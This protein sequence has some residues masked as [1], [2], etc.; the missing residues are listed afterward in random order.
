MKRN[1]IPVNE[2]LFVGNEKKYLNECIDTG[3]IGSDGKFVKKFEDKLSK[4]VGRKYGISVSSGSAALDVAF[5]ALN[6]K[7]NDEVILPTFT[8]ISCLNPILRVGAKPV[9]IDCDPNTWNMDLS[10]VEKK[11]TKKTKIILAVHIYGLPTNMYKLSE[12][13]KK[14]KI[15]IIEDAAELIG[16]KIFKKEC[17]SFGDISTFSFYTNKHITT[18]EGGM[19]FTNDKKIAENCKKLKNL[20]FEKKRFIHREVGWNYRMS[21]IQAAIGLAQLEK[22]KDF[23]KIKRNIGNKYYQGLCDEKYLDFQTGSTNYAKNI[24]WVFGIVLKKNCPITLDE[25]RKRLLIKGIQTRPFFYCLHNQPLLKNYKKKSNEFLNAEY[26]SKRGFYL[27]S[28]LNLTS[29]QLHFVVKE[30][31]KI[32]S[33]I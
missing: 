22:L 13:A 26:L 21:N 19:V 1:F 15:K 3:W 17:G 27:P 2:P 16:Q 11:I 29:K 5:K 18:G 33:K 14:Y 8:I 4:Y 32:L 7:K 6:L 12:I 9:F 23:I 24:Y 10:I 31:K 25:L 20:Y 28:G 30:L